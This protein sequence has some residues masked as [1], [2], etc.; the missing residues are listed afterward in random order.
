MANERRARATFQDE[1]YNLTDEQFQILNDKRQEQ[2][3]F[4]RT[5]WLRV[6]K[7]NGL[8]NREI[9]RRLEISPSTVSKYVKKN[10]E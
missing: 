9:A 2:S 10:L 5:F 4:W 8:S 1:W 3:I 6:M 7:E